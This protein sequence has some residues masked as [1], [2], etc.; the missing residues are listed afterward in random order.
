MD[1]ILGGELGGMTKI[2]HELFK[3][4]LA[5]EGEY[6]FRKAMIIRS[7]RGKGDHM[8]MKLFA[9]TKFS[10]I[11][12]KNIIDV[13]AAQPDVKKWLERLAKLDKA[14]PSNWCK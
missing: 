14:K 4:Q 11:L 9:R 8:F 6:N 7:Y 12:D 1:Q 10:K 2:A 13:W 5:S 3:E